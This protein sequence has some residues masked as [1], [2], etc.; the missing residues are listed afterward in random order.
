MC[1]HYTYI[2][3]SPNDHLPQ[4][5]VAFGSAVILVAVHVVRSHHVET[6]Y[7]FVPVGLVKFVVPPGSAL[8]ERV[9]VLVEY[10]SR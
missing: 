2:H 6:A 5:S 3:N 1:T 10:V 7:P 4:G 9:V 8:H